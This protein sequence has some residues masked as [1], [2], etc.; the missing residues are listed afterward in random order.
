MG[1]HNSLLEII[2]CYFR[3]Y[4]AY[5]LPDISTKYRLE[6]NNDLDPMASKRLY[7]ESGLRK[8]SYP[9]LTMIAKQV[10]SEGCSN[11]F[12]RS[13]EPFLDDDFF[14]IPMLTRR[15]LLKWLGS[16]S[17]LEGNSDICTLVSSV[18][19][20]DKMSI[21]RMGEN[22][23]LRNYIFQHMVRN[24]DISYQELLE[25]LLDFMYITDRQMAKFLESLVNPP[26][27]DTDSQ[28]Y[29]VHELNEII[30]QCGLQL[31]SRKNIAGNPI[32]KLEGMSTGIAH[33]IHNIIFAAC[34][35][36][37][38]IV[39]DDSLSNKLNILNNADKCLFYD[40]PISHEGLSWDEL[41]TW[42][43]NNNSNY[44]IETEKSLVERLKQSLDSEP[45]I[46][47]LRAYYNYL[48]KLN[49]KQLPAL[50][51]QVYCHYDPK[52]ASMR[53]GQGYVHQR[54]DFLIL[55][56]RGFR[57]IIEIDGKQHYSEGDI[58]SPPKYA[59]MVRDDRNLKLYGYDVYRFGGQEFTVHDRDLIIML[60]NFF[61]M[62]FRKYELI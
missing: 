37:P 62:L 26:T 7:L 61:M 24:D 17:D 20:I 15:I 18:W 9:E 47:F 54:M 31:I 3:E 4:K 28:A 5:H 11:D 21:P 1:D 45:E 42:W 48:Y 52:T 38:D 33:P 22:V 32:Y 43:N 12:V 8:K 59:T 25:D 13:V 36:K 34:G 35:C 30:S 39:I 14:A 44:D 56:P 51:P 57:V 53:N 23:S 46:K 49:N 41:V 50:I 58:A 27:R 19:E 60:E 6:C 2:V 55:L 16:Q 10:I 40:L 29:Y